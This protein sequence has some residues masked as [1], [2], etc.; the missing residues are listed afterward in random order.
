M[1]RTTSLAAAFTAAA[2]FATPVAGASAATTSTAPA[3]VAASA[4]SAPGDI[5]LPGAGSFNPDPLAV[6]ALPFSNF[7]LI[8]TSAFVVTGY[9]MDKAGKVL[10]DE[11]DEPLLTLDQF[12]D[13]E[14]KAVFEKFGGDYAAYEAATKVPIK[15][16][17]F[18]AVSDAVNKV[19]LKGDFATAS[20]M[21]QGYMAQVVT[22]VMDLPGGL[23]DL[24]VRAFFPPES[25][26][27]LAVASP[28]AANP[29]ALPTVTEL[30]DVA[31]IP[32]YN[33]NQGLGATIVDTRKIDDEGK[34]IKANIY[35]A[36]NATVN[37]AL[38]GKFSEAAAQAQD[39]LGQ[40][41]DNMS[42]LP[43][44]VVEHDL[45]KLHA[46]FPVIPAL[47][48]G[49]EGQSKPPAPA[50][51][52]TSA[53]VSV[54]EKAPASSAREDVSVTGGGDRGESSSETVT[55]GDGGTID[56]DKGRDV[57]DVVKDALDGKN[58]PESAGPTESAEPTGAEQAADEDSGADDAGATQEA[59][60]E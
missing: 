47:P 33:L 38:T 1:N 8:R 29:F 18:T 14:N 9:K 25:V 17:I 30:L 41:A 31:S 13:A 43:R 21:I 2:I 22:Q 10:V 50:V 5:A 60:A 20:A 39:Y 56:S 52:A 34:P 19:A 7:E 54:G 15:A 58:E 48:K 46:A 26:G 32:L 24:N 45:E 12:D 40:F 42:S 11:N 57:L 49:D 16:N 37:L 51:D 27:T 3:A 55:G 23:F 4:A 59:S 28:A 6:L 44:D 35:S 36:L 53:R